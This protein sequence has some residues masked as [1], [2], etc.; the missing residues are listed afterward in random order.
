MTVAGETHRC[1]PHEVLAAFVDA[2]LPKTQVVALSEH[3]ATCAECRFVVESASELQ[4]EEQAESV[5]PKRRRSWRWL[6][7]AAVVGVGVWVTPVT[8]AK[9][10]AYQVKTVRQD[11]VEK[12]DELKMRPTAARLTGFEYGEKPRVNRGSG[13]SPEAQSIILQSKAQQLIELTKH[14]HSPAAAHERGI[15][16]L[17]IGDVDTAISDLKAAAAAN[18]AQAWSDLSAAYYVKR[19]Y[20]EA[21]DAANR[22]IKIDPKLS[23]AWFNRAL[24]VAGIALTDPVV[25]YRWAKKTSSPSVEYAP[26]TQEPL[27]QMIV[28]GKATEV[29]RMTKGKRTPDA[30]HARGIAHLVL[31]HKAEAVDELTA[32]AKA[33]PDDVRVLSDL[34]TALLENQEYKKA[35][36]AAKRAQALDSQQPENLANLNA[37]YQRSG[38]AE[39]AAWNDY[40]KHDS[41]SR[42]ANEARE[43]IKDVQERS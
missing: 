37:A 19:M 13:E 16:E 34:A 1:P 39:I 10:H 36:D 25:Q 24:A 43:N 22:A 2:R 18:D 23:D 27:V 21:A 5:E 31:H 32:V 42:W 26:L 38:E 20:V 14:D 41:T 9:W 17:I 6:A 15:G 35:L 40:L 33:R 28:D 8:M 7:V 11:L 12:F 3:L 4:A 30:M 29:L